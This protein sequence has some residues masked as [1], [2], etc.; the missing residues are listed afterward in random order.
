[1]NEHLEKLDDALGKLHGAI[2]AQGI[3]EDLGAYGTHI[4]PIGKRTLLKS[5]ELLRLQISMAP[6]IPLPSN[7]EEEIP[8]ILRQLAATS[9]NLVPQLLS[10]NAASAAPGLLGLLWSISLRLQPA[11][12][13][14][15]VT[16]DQRIPVGVVSRVKQLQQSLDR[17][18]AAIQELQRQ[19]SESENVLGNV[20]TALDAGAILAAQFEKLSADTN[21]AAEGVQAAS[22]A[23]AKALEETTAN[24]QNASDN[25][26]LVAAAAEQVEAAKKNIDEQALSVAN[27]SGQVTAQA[28]SV[29]QAEQTAKS[30]AS[31]GLSARERALTESTKIAEILTQVTKDQGEVQ[32]RK[33]EVDSSAENVG[34]AEK[35]SMDAARRADQF[36]KDADGMASKSKEA[37]RI[38]TATGLAGAFH[39]RARQLNIFTFLW[40]A[41]LAGALFAAAYMGKERTKEISELLAAGTVDTGVLLIQ[42]VLSILTVGAPVWLAWLGTKQ[43]SHLFR[44]AEDYGFK[45]TIA[46]AYEG[47][48]DQAVNIDRQFEARL[49]SSALQRLDENPLRLVIETQPG[50]PLHELL[51]QPKFQ[52]L[53]NSVPEFKDKIIDALK[54]PLPGSISK[55]IRPNQ[56]AGNATDP[57]KPA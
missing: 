34:K 46:K 51:Q 8:E 41:V 54:G 12:G 13:W 19:E 53:M 15:T 47:F 29:S 33:T 44:L 27:L 6:D 11:V 25:A 3:P 45:A 21:A 23:A 2:S 35:H 38:V 18:E 48:R 26:K 1:M 16:T 7:V 5:V 40:L 57:Q 39:Q 56:P 32:A 43:V 52:E 49:F 50:S 20:R 17:V 31:E 9:T 30:A 14:A 37:Y 36:A 10:A 28:T 24:A 22:A 4:V 55:D 42:T